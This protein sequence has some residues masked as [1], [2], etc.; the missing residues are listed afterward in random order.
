MRCRFSPSLAQG[1]V[2]APHSKSMAHRA[3][4]CAALAEGESRIGPVAS[5]EDMLATMDALSALGASFTRDGDFVL[6]QGTDCLHPVR[7]TISC[8]E[9]GSTLRFCVPL[10]LLSGKPVTLTGAGR[11]M[12]RPMG[13]YE[14]LCGEKGFLYSHTPESITLCGTLRPGDYHIPG[15]VS[16][17]FITGL[18]LALPLLSGDSILHVT[19]A[20]ESAAYVDMTLQVMADFGVAVSRCGNDF[21][22]PGG[23]RYVNRNYTVEGDYSNAAFLEGFSLLGGTVQ[24]DGLQEDSLQGDRVYRHIYSSLQEGC[25]T[26]DIKDCPDLGPVV[27]ALAA[28]QNGA[29]LTGTSRLKLKESDRGLAMAQELAKCGVHLTLEGNRIL[30]PGGK[31]RT[32]ESVIS[33]HNDHRIVM[34]MSLLLSRLGGVL[35]GAE[36][37]RKSY[38]DFFTVIK[39]LGIE[40]I[41]E[42]QA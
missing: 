20:L 42:I 17:Q 34:A 40:V 39:Q 31:L 33:S 24:V 35:D 21:Y 32:P 26:I 4:F 12:Q 3:L 27:I 19:G 23:H 29:T 41:T 1:T 16:S 37:V 8:R 13:V 7:Q 36:A 5:S 11:L 14:S 18:L 30:V 38:P 25:P 10:C 15:H 22:I 6:V 28:A 2:Q 9:S